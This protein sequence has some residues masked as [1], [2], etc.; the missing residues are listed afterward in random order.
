MGTEDRKIINEPFGLNSRGFL[1]K[2]VQWS[3]EGMLAQRRILVWI[4]V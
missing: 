2:S 1:D 4:E 3:G